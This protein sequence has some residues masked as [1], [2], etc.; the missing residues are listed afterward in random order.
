LGLCLLFLKEETGLMLRLPFVEVSAFAGGLQ[1]LGVKKGDRVV[2]YMP[3]VL[4]TTV[5]ML[6][7]ARLGAVHSVVF[8]GF[9][10]LELAARIEDATPK[11]IISASCGVE[12]KGIIDYGPLLN[13]AL[14]RSAWK[15]STVVMMQRDLCPFPM[16]KGRDVDW[17]D[18]M[19][20]GSP[21]DAVPVLAT[22]P[23]YILYTSGTTGRPKGVVRDNGGHAVALK[24]AMRNVFDITPDDT[25]FA[26]SDMGW[27]VGHSLVVYGPLVHGCTVRFGRLW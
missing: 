3:A 14:E 9:A 24:W 21:V 25:F 5:A 11:V 8:G 20:M 13:G 27:T 17:N 19:A 2:I 26:A 4:E 16:K 6:A 18:A 1:K 12:P 10:T 15:P 23:L 7:C 22:D